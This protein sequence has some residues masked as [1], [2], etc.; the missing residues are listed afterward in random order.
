MKIS[1]IYLK[2]TENK[3]YVENAI[4]QVDLGIVGNTRTLKM[5]RQVSIFSEEDRKN[6]EELEVHGLCTLR[7][8]EDITIKNLIFADIIIGNKLELGN[9]I[10]EITEIGKRCFSECSLFKEKKPCPLTKGIIY[11]KVI[12]GGEIRIGDYGVIR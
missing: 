11:A 3:G 7:F 12:S 6:L 8:H 9:L 4:L 5:D 1:R 2:N 10:L